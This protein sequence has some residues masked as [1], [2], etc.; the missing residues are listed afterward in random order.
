MN[1][2]NDCARRILLEIAKMPNGESLTVGN[3]AEKMPEFSIGDVQFI[4]T[5]FHKGYYLNVL[6]KASF[7]DS[8]V[9]R[10]NKIKGL[11]EK[12]YRVLD[13]IRNDKA[14]NLM[15]EKIDNFDELSIFTIFNI[16]NKIFNVKH[17]ELLDLPKDLVVQDIK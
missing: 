16:A 1:I 10:E 13:L 2:N 4:V 12:G 3:L 9:F 8:D 5:L 6:D 17:N 15:K 11:T 14:W 7:D